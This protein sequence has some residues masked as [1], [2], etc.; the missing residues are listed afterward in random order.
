LTG[1]VPWSSSGDVLRW[2][3]TEILGLS[4]QQVA[5]RLSV[6]PTALSN[7]ENGTRTISID[8]DLIDSALEGDG[9]LGGL[10]WSFG[11]PNG[12]EA[13]ELWTK[14]FPGKPTPVWMWIRSR[15]PSLH[16]TAEWGIARVEV[17][18]DVPPN[19]LFITVALSVDE[20]PVVVHFSEP[21][22]A[23]FGRG[24]LPDEIPG[25]VILPANEHASRSAGS[26]TFYEL[27]FRNLGDRFSRSRSRQLAGLNRSAPRSLAGFFKRF[28]TKGAADLEGCDTASPWPPLPDATDAGAVSASPNCA[29]PASS[30]SSTRS[31]GFTTS[32]ASTSRR[33][34][35]AGSR[36]VSANRTI[37][38]FPQHSTRCSVPTGTLPSSS[39]G[40]TRARAQCGFPRTGSG[41][42]GSSSPDPT[43]R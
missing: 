11:T 23:D 35:F 32:P 41:P 39:F 2:W 18:I 5:S 43:R 26:G 8:L 12:L 22:W 36:P 4:Q 14:V 29:K 17:D 21:S 31:A 38:S 1:V 10:L 20:A 37:G 24:D 3:R 34:P 33:T 19:G 28:S 27:F 6:M 15:A 7:W 16:V 30:H 13:N 9:V 40:L 42:C 25:A